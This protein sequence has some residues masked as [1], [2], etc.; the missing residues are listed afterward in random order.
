MQVVA[1]CTANLCRSPLAGFVLR[2]GLRSRGAAVEVLS[3]GVHAQPGRSV[4]ADWLAV[5]TRLGVDLS[6]H[7][8][9]HVR[10]QL[11]TA[12]LF[13]VM[14]AEHARD[15]ALIDSRA[16]GR[17]LT[18]GEAAQRLEQSANRRTSTAPFALEQRAADVLNMD[19][20]WDIADPVRQP[21]RAQVRI[22]EQVID[23]CER[24]VRGWP[25]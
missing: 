9:C 10:D 3:G 19:R 4:P 6:G 15:L 18:L 1:I 21:E 25:C 16:V 8:S 23:L 22:A 7:R 17:V 12:D 14:T 24:I 2:E 13:L 11:A 20:R 5:T